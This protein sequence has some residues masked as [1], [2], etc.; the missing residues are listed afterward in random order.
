MTLPTIKVRYESGHEVAVAGA[1]RLSAAVQDVQR[2]SAAGATA[3]GRLSGALQSLGNVSGQTR[4]RIQQASFQIQDLA[5][6]LQSGTRASVALSQQLPQLAGAFGAVGAA[7]GVGVALG[8]P[9]LSLAMQNL[10]DDSSDLEDAIEAAGEAAAEA[11]DRLG[12]LE[13]GLRSLDEYRLS[14]EV[15]AVSRRIL[16]IEQ[17]LAEAEERKGRGRNDLSRALRGQLEI[18]YALRDTAQEQLD[19]LI[20]ANDQLAQMQSEP[21]L[22]GR[23]GDPRQFEDDPYWEAQR[24]PDA[25]NVKVKRPR[26]AGRKKKIEEELSEE[27]KRLKEHMDILAGL[28]EDGLGNQLNAW[29]NYF[30]HLGQSAGRSGRDLVKAAKVTGSALALIDAWQAH[31]ATLRDPML[32]WWMRIPAALQVAAA[33]F[34]AVDAISGVSGGGGG[35]GGSAAGGAAAAQAA[36]NYNFTINQNVQGDFF[37]A[38]QFTSASRGLVDVVVAEVNRRGGNFNAV[39]T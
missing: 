28:T 2:R 21:V 13:S 8:I 7:I 27:Q 4:S 37:T 15:E 38:E 35:G 14:R 20:S 18:Q 17:Q 31:N 34:G 32:P 9:A 26:I 6:Q 10:T 36:Q 24:F 23:G 39:F 29:S 11:A 33:G 12:L 16:E 1:N 3:S 30:D 22:G 25:Q 5:V 19:A